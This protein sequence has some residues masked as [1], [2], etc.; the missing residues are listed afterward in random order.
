MRRPTLTELSNFLAVTKLQSGGTRLQGSLNL[1]EAED[2][3]KLLFMFGCTG[4]SLLQ[5]LSLAVDSS[6]YSLVLL[7]GLLISVTS[8]A[9]EYGL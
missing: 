8:P 4:S 9:V 2:L 1:A 5:E 3:S 7:H 6:S